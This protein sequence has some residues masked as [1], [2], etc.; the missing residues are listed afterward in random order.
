MQTA[1]IIWLVAIVAFIVLEA[2]TYQM[3]SLW[4]I[5]GAIGGLIAS[6]LGAG[7]WVQ[8]TVFL[9]ISVA[10]LLAFRPMVVKRLS[11]NNIKTNADSVIGK[12][13]LITETVDNT[14][15]TGQGRIDGAIWTV[16]SESGTIIEAGTLAIIKEI[17]G[18]KLIVE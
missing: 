10:L 17:E 5:V 14:N 6:L 3:V 13:I 12:K 15:S 1:G 18:V 7:F 2:T 8:M 16:R 4:F 11:K 9:V